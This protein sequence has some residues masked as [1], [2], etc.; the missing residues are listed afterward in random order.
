MSEHS[1]STL[2]L[3]AILAHPD[4]ETF[5]NGATLARYAAEGVDVTVVTATRGQRGWFGDPAAFPGMEAL[6][7][8][9]ESELRAAAKA[10]GLREVVVLDQ[11]DGD[12]QQADSEQVVCELV[13][14]IRRVRPQVV[15][16][17]GPDGAYGHPDHMAISQLTTTAIVRAAD[18]RYGHH[19]TSRGPH[20]V[21]KLYHMALTAEHAATYEGAFGDIRMLVD[22]TER[23][24]VITPDWMVSARIDAGV[25]WRAAWQAAACH[26]TQIPNYDTLAGMTEVEQRHL[27]S[28]NEYL[29]VFST[30][31]VSPGR[32]DD[33]FAG[34]RPTVADRLEVAA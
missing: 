5:G 21:S 13:A 9:R 20:A 17:F 28:T 11:L 12:L 24:P 26:R 4:D 16:T 2:R 33:L 6:G 19:C 25:H 14:H 30:V 8:Q 32:E 31:P 18:A 34:L 23:R 7:Q 1:T 10:L 22:G 27:W 15:L 3:M 29:R